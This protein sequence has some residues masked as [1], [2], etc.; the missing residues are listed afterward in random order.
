MYSSVQNGRRR[1]VVAPITSLDI[2]C[3]ELPQKIGL[4]VFA[5]R[6]TCWR[7]YTHGVSVTLDL[8]AEVVARLQGEATRRGVS[9]DEVIAEL[10]ARLPADATPVPR[11]TLA[12]LGAGASAAGITT[13]LDETLAEGFGRD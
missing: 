7:S 8:S 10:A 3:S 6:P 5:Q 9:I 2:C 4:A 1:H 12:F 13:C 11:R